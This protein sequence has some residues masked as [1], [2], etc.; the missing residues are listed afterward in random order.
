MKSPARPNLNRLLTKW[1]RRLRLQDW[2]ITA[3]YVRSLAREGSEDEHIFGTCV[4]QPHHQAAEIE[5][6]DPKYFP[7]EYPER[8]A[9]VEL[10]FVHEL[11]HV[12]FAQAFSHI[13]EHPLMDE[14]QERIV[15]QMAKAL[16]EV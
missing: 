1:Q 14:I 9:S 11:C 15:E 10:T 8:F 6:L 12:V 4:P 13:E 7:A 2:D 5:I 16:L 3:R